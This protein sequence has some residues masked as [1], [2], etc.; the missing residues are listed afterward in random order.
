MGVASKMTPSREPQS[1][2]HRFL[3]WAPVLAWMAVIFLFSSD[4]FSSENT[5]PLIAPILSNLFPNL[6][7]PHIENIVQMMRKL[8]HLSEYFILG[9]FFMRA[10]NAEFAD[11]SGRQ[12]I[13]WSL[14]FVIVYAASDELHQAFV[15]SRTACIGD[16]G[17]DGLG[18]ICGILWFHVR[19][20]D[21]KSPPT[22]LPT[23]TA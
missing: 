16:V 18:G 2:A 19:K 5:T 23:G 1:A 3:S 22:E 6:G 10:L 12:Q 4:Y 13:L 8:G 15:P 11:R 21:K 7:A 14:V 20:R 17:I 9:L